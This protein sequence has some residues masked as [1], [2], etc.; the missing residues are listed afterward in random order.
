MYMCIH[1]SLVT[2]PLGDV[3]VCVWFPFHQKHRLRGKSRLERL[4]I[5]EEELLRQ[6]QQLFEEA[7]QQ[8]L[9]VGEWS[10]CCHGYIISLAEQTG[11]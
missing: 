2:L 6:Q 8:H 5:P 7:R 10:S 4:G 1:T 11:L 9:E 3:M